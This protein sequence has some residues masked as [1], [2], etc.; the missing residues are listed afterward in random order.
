MLPKCSYCHTYFLFFN[1]KS[2]D[3]IKNSNFLVFNRKS[4]D[5]I[6]QLLESREI[7]KR[8]WNQHIGYYSSNLKAFATGV[9]VQVN[10]LSNV[11]NTRKSRLWFCHQCRRGRRCRLRSG[12]RLRALNLGLQ[13][14]V[15]EGNALLDGGTIDLWSS[16]IAKKFG[17]YECY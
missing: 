1:R 13:G 4:D 14:E 8:Y 15:E 6:K 2:D 12:R 7:E 10:I 17:S 11:G 3:L 16:L 5:L 9:Q